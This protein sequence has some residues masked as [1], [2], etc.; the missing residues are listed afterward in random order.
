MSEKIIDEVMEMV[1]KLEGAV[2]FGN[3]P[4]RF[5]AREAI[6]AK[7]REV[8]DS[9]AELGEC[10]GCK[11]LYMKPFPTQCDCLENPENKYLPWVA[12]R[13]YNIGAE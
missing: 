7:L 6:R 8:L 12:R 5:H 10:V 9:Q 3:Q 4:Q 13:T 11:H 2:D 1:A